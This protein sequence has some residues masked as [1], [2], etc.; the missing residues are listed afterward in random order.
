MIAAKGLQKTYGKKTYLYD[1]S[2]RLQRG[3]ALAVAGENGAGKTTLLKILATAAL[4][5]KGSLFI[6][7]VNAIDDVAAVRALIGYVP[8]SIALMQELSVKDNLYYW[9]KTKDKQIY[10]A[11]VE[12]IGL[13]SVTKKRV[14]KLSG[15]M[16]RRLKDRKSVV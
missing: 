10:N 5:D 9:M 2:F 6:G 1:V 13:K 16:Q 11:V 15:G 12:L 14:S 8:Q 7:G 3:R 4:P